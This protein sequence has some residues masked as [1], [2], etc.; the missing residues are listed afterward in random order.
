MVV[1]IVNVGKREVQKLVLVCPCLLTIRKL[2]H[3][4]RRWWGVGDLGDEVRS[5]SLG[6]SVNQDSNKRDLNQGVEAQSKPEEDALAAPEPVALLLLCE[7]DPGEVRLQQLS[8]QTSGR[9]ICLQED[10]EV[11]TR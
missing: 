9:E 8:H 11:P 6:N 10:D 2:L 4:C 5:R 7:V 3:L 1:Y